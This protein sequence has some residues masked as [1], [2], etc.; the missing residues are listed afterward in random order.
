M[1]E[2]EHCVLVA[3]ERGLLAPDTP[4]PL[5]ELARTVNGLINYRTRS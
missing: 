4:L 1:K 5:D 2:T 3:K